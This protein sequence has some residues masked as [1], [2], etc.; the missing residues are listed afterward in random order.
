MLIHNSLHLLLKHTDVNYSGWIQEGVGGSDNP[1][2]PDS[3][4]E[5][6]D[7]LL[8]RI[9]IRCSARQPH[10]GILGIYDNLILNKI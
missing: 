7:G 8:R 3:L 6:R 10:T 5:H 2:S 4:H 1:R 9:Q